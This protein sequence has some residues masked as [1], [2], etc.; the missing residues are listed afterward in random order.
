[1]AFLHSKCIGI[2]FKNSM[3][4]WK[5]ELTYQVMCIDIILAF[6]LLCICQTY[7]K[8]PND[9]SIYS[10][11]G[12]DFIYV[13]YSAIKW[14]KNWIIIVLMNQT[15]LH[16]FLIV[17]RVWVSCVGE[18]WVLKS[19]VYDHLIIINLIIIIIV[20]YLCMYVV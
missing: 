19:L 12:N 14:H 4:H 17:F 9:V 15:G 8:L 6:K 7:H 13:W 3:L 1:M 18:V 10:N 16:L 20:M 2:T 5:R 11:S